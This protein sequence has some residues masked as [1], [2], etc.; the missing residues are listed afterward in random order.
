M[1][2]L[3]VRLGLGKVVGTGVGLRMTWANSGCR[4]GRLGL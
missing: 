2:F 3:V 1:L 4:I